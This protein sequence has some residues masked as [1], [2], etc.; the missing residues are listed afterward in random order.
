M[1]GRTL[2]G[3]VGADTAGVV[4]AG[5]PFAFEVQET[6]E[7]FSVVLREG[8]VERTAEQAGVDYEQVEVLSSLYVADP[9]LARLM[10]SF[11]P[12]IKNRNLGSE[13]YAE[14]LASQL[15]VHLLRHHSSLGRRH[16]LKVVRP[17][18]HQVSRRAI[19]RVRDYVNDNLAGSLS[20]AEMAEAAG[21]SPH[22]FARLFKDATGLTPHRYV[23]GRRVEVAKNL[24]EATELSLAEVARLCGF[25]DQSHMGRNVKALTGATPARLR[26]ESRR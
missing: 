25:S 10:R 1:D 17:P 13:L 18:T 9:Q 26:R 15:A 19:S 5:Q 3:T 16:K 23:V 24:L 4:P 7:T 21:Y 8:F 14:A 22:H 2:E 12:E 11:L 6:I 20:L